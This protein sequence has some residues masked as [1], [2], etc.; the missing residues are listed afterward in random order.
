MSPSI[1][2]IKVVLLLRLQFII[3]ND[4]EARKKLDFRGHSTT[5]DRH[6]IFIDNRGIWFQK[7]NQTLTLLFDA[8]QCFLGGC[9]IDGDNFHFW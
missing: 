8:T 5:Y 1:C 9:G 6:F 7:T 2:Y 4:K 3:N